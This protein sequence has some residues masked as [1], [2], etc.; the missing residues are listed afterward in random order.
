MATLVLA[1]VLISGLIIG[2][3]AVPYI[4]D[5]VSFWCALGFGL[6]EQKTQRKGTTGNG[7]AGALDGHG[8]S[9]PPDAA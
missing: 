1:L 8:R 7:T 5:M 9:M 2:H 4:R 3:F 6:M